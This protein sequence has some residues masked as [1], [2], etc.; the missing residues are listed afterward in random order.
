M[1]NVDH[2]LRSKISRST[3]PCPIFVTNVPD[4]GT[5]ILQRKH[6]AEDPKATMPTMSIPRRAAMLVFGVFEGEVLGEASALLPPP[7]PLLLLPIPP[8][9]VGVALPAEEEP[10]L[11]ALAVNVVNPVFRPILLEV[12]LPAEDEASDEEVVELE[13]PVS[14]WSERTNRYFSI[15][16]CALKCA[17]GRIR[18]IAA[19][20][21]DVVLNIANAVLAYGADR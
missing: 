5:N 20:L 4:V 19:I 9:E 11:P 21:R 16:G 12:E 15:L 7:L 18:G 8:V 10:A 2:A 6:R 1:S 14:T 17:H 13:R 3:P